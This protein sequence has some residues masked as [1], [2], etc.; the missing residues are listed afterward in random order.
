[1]Q[2]LHLSQPVLNFIIAGI[3]TNGGA[4]PNIIPE[5]AELLYFLRAPTVPELAVLKEK[6][7]GCIQG[8]ATA[9]GCQVCE[10]FFSTVSG[11]MNYSRRSNS[12]PFQFCDVVGFFHS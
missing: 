4:K 6:V 8:A 7:I 11:D 10:P 3:I 5:L 2:H 9:T 12:E 1:M